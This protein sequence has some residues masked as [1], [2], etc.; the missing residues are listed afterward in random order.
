MNSITK[1]VLLIL[2]C[3]VMVI[4]VKPSALACQVPAFYHTREG[5]LAAATQETLIAARKFEGEGNQEKLADLMKSGTVRRLTANIKV[6]V[7]ERS[8]EF[9]TMRIKLPGEDTT[10]W[11]KDGSLQLI[12]CK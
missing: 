6:P 3:G 10:Y 8:F 7:L 9:K 2:V 1:S 11:V 5:F 12:D 4:S